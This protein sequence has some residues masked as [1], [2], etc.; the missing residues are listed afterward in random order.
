[1]SN[2]DS[3]TLKVLQAAFLRPVAGLGL[4]EDICTSLHASEIWY[5]FDLMQT[6]ESELLD[7]PDFDL[8]RVTEIKDTLLGL[9]LG[10]ANRSNDTLVTQALELLQ[11]NLSRSVG[12]LEIS[13]KTQN[14]LR[15]VGIHSIGDL[16]KRT[17]I[18]Y[19]RIPNL[20][21]K[22]ME[23]FPALSKEG[24][25]LRE[26]EQP[27]RKVLQERGSSKKTIKVI[28]WVILWTVLAI[29]LAPVVA[30]L[31]GFVFVLIGL[32]WSLVF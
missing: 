2:D 17:E 25:S 13:V 23:L 4:K 19:L 18:E 3:Q 16:I 27:N 11:E 26:E 12:D 14:D 20:G 5:V 24:Y 30:Y 1:M 8:D 15:S 29:V 32:L 22:H 7:T 9:G 28:G 6:T 31:S 21:R 10:L